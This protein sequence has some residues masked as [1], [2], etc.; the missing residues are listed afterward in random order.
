MSSCFS[1]RSPI[2]ASILVFRLHTA[3]TTKPKSHNHPKR[4]EL[5]STTRK[6]STNRA[7]W[8]QSVASQFATARTQFQLQ[9]HQ[10]NQH[11]Q[12]RF[13]CGSFNLDACAGCICNKHVSECA[14]RNATPGTS[15]PLSGM[16]QS[17]KHPHGSRRRG[18]PRVRFPIDD[19]V[20]V[21]LFSKPAATQ[22]LVRRRCSHNDPKDYS[23]YTK[24]ITLHAN[25]RRRPRPRQ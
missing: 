19:C 7:I 18:F 13:F 16:V 22:P 12:K 11:K 20:D 15:A 2:K 3:R 1:L 6:G 8:T 9:L 4:F 10:A 25:C 5:S 23:N 24:R 21:E 14:V 17:H